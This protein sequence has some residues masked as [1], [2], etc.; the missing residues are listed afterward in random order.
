MIS[1][2][3]KTKWT[4]DWDNMLVLIIITRSGPFELEINSF[5]KVDW[6]NLLFF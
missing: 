1:H 5:D 6:D 2:L 4:V 3:E